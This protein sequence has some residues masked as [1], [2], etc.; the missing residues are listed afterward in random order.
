MTKRLKEDPLRQDDPDAPPP[1]DPDDVPPPPE[2]GDVDPAPGGTTPKK[3]E[4]PPD[5][6]NPPQDNGVIDPPDQVKGGNSDAL[7]ITPLPEDDVFGGTINPG[8]GDA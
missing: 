2:R 5:P 3:G 4:L 6:G 7:P 8:P 1:A